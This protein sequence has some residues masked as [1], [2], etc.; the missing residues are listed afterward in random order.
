M[1]YVKSTEAWAA[2]RGLDKTNPDK[3]RMERV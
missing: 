1:D 2:N 3:L